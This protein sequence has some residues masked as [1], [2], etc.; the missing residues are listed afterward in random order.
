MDILR[1]MKTL[2][3]AALNGKRV[4]LRVNTDVPLTKDHNIADDF[5]L[6]TML[7]T[8][9][10][11]IDNQAKIILT[12]HLGRPKGQYS[13][14]LSLKKVYAHLS[15]L[16]K[17]P[18]IF[19]PTLFEPP[20]KKAVENLQPGQIL[21]LE[22]I[23]FDLGEEKNSRTF[24]VKLAKYGDIF[25]NEDFSVAHHAGASTVAIT[26]LLPSYAG[27]LFEKE[28]K[29]LSN[30][31]KHPAHPY[32]AIIGGAKVADKLPVIKQFIRLADWVLVGGGVA[33]TFLKASGTDIKGSLF[34]P[35]CLDLATKILKEAKGKIVLPVD[36][37]WSGERM[38]DIDSRTIKL[39]NS[40]IKGAKTI[41]WSGPLG[42]V[43]DPRFKS[44][45]KS[46][47]RSIVESSATTVV[48]GGDTVGFV[49][50]IN[51][52]N[53]FSFVSTGG[54]ATLDLISGASLPAVQAL[55]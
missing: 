22:N 13:A 10:Y 46:V 47:A 11:L 16:L 37:V 19:A 48:G 29:I 4:I 24:A 23:R 31:M 17:K 54:S 27:L 33:N 8:L 21:A 30:L 53:K 18:I 5:R 34:D 38:M 55:N 2:E 6:R 35:K 43:E 42:M 52:A 44:G 20:T 39:F 41:F 28:Y 1:L 49:D 40:H 36:F 9:H 15:I 45:S 51:L 25:V 50:S 14:D 7:P 32:V 3:E 26:D 12:G